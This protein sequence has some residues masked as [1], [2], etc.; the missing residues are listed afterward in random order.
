MIRRGDI[1]FHMK[2]YFIL[3][4]T[5][6]AHI[7]FAASGERPAMLVQK[8]LEK[9]YASFL[10][11]IDE[12]EQQARNEDFL[13]NQAAFFESRLA[14]K[15]IEL[16][17]EY[18]DREYLKDFIN[19][20]PLPSLERKST[21]LAAIEPSGFQIAE[22]FLCLKKTGKHLEALSVTFGPNHIFLAAIFQ[23]TD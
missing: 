10:K 17:F 22:E 15:K 8:K 14:Y 6:V 11:E 12:L 5:L 3:S 9:D 4:L 2:K 23:S 7:V 21:D 16:F 1:L 19:G 20:A 13:A 18:I